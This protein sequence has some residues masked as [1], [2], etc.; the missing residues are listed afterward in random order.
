MAREQTRRMNL[1]N[2]LAE[3]DPRTVNAQ[4]AF[5]LENLARQRLAAWWER[6]ERTASYPATDDDAVLLC[7]SVE[8][9]IDRESLVRFIDVGEFDG[10]AIAD[11]QRKWSA[12]D[13][14]RLATFLE[15]RRGWMPGS[16]LHHAKKTIYELAL[17]R[18]RATGEAHELFNDLERYD[19]R[20]LLLLLTESDS[21]QQREA[22]KVAIELKLETYCITV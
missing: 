16:E 15:C 4:E 18:F 2:Q 20:A 13:I 8:Y 9:A 5:T 21:R 12:T 19:L 11:G 1:P 17:E 14:A 10:V 22:L 7:R 6:A 3:R